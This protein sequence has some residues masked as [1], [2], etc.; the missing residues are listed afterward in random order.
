MR[1]IGDR[2]KEKHFGPHQHVA[3]KFGPLVIIDSRTIILVPQERADILCA[4]LLGIVITAVNY[5]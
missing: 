3:F 2:K 1:G 4:V 5:P